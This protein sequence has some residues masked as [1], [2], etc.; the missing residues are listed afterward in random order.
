MTD[1][2]STE[3]RMAGR[4]RENDERSLHARMKWFTKK[5]TFEL[6][7]HASAEFSADFMIVVQAIHRDA[8]RETHA[9][10]MKALMAAPP[11]PIF[12][13]KTGYPS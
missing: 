4:D 11:Q 1:Q 12:I 6:D 7:K 9:L 13:P 8:N 2:T 5:W 3:L 10:L